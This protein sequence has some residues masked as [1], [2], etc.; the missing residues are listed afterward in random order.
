MQDKLAIVI[1]IPC[2]QKGRVATCIFFARWDAAY[3]LGA[4]VPM[5]LGMPLAV[6][7]IYI[8]E[9]GRLAMSSTAWVLGAESATKQSCHAYSKHVLYS[10]FIA[11]SKSR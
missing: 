8:G 11:D 7:L 9:V 5:N 10:F 1:Y 3:Y 4:A 6:V 2:I